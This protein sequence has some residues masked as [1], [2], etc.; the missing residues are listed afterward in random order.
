M[1]LSESQ[2]WNECICHHLTRTLYQYPTIVPFI[3]L[4]M[5]HDHNH[6]LFHPYNARAVMLKG[7][8]DSDV[9]ASQIRANKYLII[10]LH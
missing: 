4:S 7:S 6:L 1:I 10:H 2:V 5:C 9:L 8:D 3:M